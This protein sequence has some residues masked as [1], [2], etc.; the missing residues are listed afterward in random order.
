M[1][2]RRAAVARVIKPDSKY[3][4]VLISKFINNLMVDGKK[5]VAEKIVYG[6]F[7]RIEKKN[8][9]DPNKIF[10]ECMDNVRPYTEV[11]S[12]RVGGTNYQVPSPVDEKRGYALAT[13]YIIEAATKRSGRSMID[14]LGDE[15]FDGA[16]SRGSAFKKREDVHKMAES[17]KAFSHFAQRS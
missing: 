16:N 13:R 12:V 2:R 11:K 8:G 14:K 5:S 15:M 10:T 1:S 7:S 9:A 17:N 3:N 4:S 6:A